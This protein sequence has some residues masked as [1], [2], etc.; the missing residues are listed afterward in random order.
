M[1]NM[2]ERIA[3]YDARRAQRVLNV[4]HRDEAADALVVDALRE[5][6]YAAEAGHQGG[7]VG[8]ECLWCSAV[9]KGRGALKA[10]GK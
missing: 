6:I 5:L 7:K 8:C 1:T 2:E 3:A 10:L 4:E 9:R